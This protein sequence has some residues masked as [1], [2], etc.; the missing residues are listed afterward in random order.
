MSA[1]QVV[2]ALLANY[3]SG[4]GFE[5]RSG[6]EEGTGYA[7]L[8]VLV[9]GPNG[10]RRLFGLRFIE[11]P[12]LP[13]T[14]RFWRTERWEE[15][16]FE[17]DFTTVGDAGCGTRQSPSNVPTMCIPFH[18]DYYRDSWHRDQPWNRNEA[19]NQIGELVGD[20]LRRA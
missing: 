14:L 18:T 6:T 15:R 13:P 16:A 7:W 11:F 5:V 3:F 20:I 10:P 9:R 19:E 1:N 2:G 12:V 8:L 17:F 4:Q